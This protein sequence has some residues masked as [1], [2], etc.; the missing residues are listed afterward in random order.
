[1][2]KKIK[3]VLIALSLSFAFATSSFAAGLLGGIVGGLLGVKQVGISNEQFIT[4]AV[5]MLTEKGDT[6]EVLALMEDEYRKYGYEVTRN[7]GENEPI[8]EWHIYHSQL[9]FHGTVEINRQVHTVSL[10]Y[11]NP[12]GGN[13]ELKDGYNPV[14]EELTWKPKDNTQEPIGKTENYTPPKLSVSELPVSNSLKN[15]SVRKPKIIKS[16]I[17]YASHDNDNSAFIENN[18]T[19]C[20]E[21]DNSKIKGNSYI[22]YWA[23][24]I[25]NGGKDF[26]YDIIKSKIEA[27]AKEKKDPFSATTMKKAFDALIAYYKAGNPSN[28][29]AYW[30]KDFFCP[31]D[32]IES[33]FNVTTESADKDVITEFYYTTSQRIYIS[34]PTVAGI[35]SLSDA[36]NRVGRYAF[37]IPVAKAHEAYNK[38][39]SI[40]EQNKKAID[41]LRTMPKGARVKITAV[42]VLYGLSGI[43]R[44]LGEGAVF[45]PVFA[46]GVYAIK[47][48]DG[49]ATSSG[50]YDFS[51]GQWRDLVYV[52]QNSPFEN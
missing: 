16:I 3:A 50:K 21:F 48:I 17:G 41:K 30:M 36:P 42:R 24:E 23:Y 32:R 29:Y 15:V 28:V 35:L 10:K 14:R 2:R 1:M 52:E 5:K 9:N 31:T 18:K 45:T 44:Y 46:N 13:Y 39:V 8:R 47:I 40:T 19:G 6:N 11:K 33:I 7:N 4:S 22:A 27:I 26:Y 25:A 37:E 49:Y 34:L 43:N 51:T 12:G 20:A 38:L